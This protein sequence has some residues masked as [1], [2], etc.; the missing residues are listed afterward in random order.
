MLL[1]SLLA[2]ILFQVTQI[3]LISVILLLYLLK[4]LQQ[5]APILSI[6][7]L[8]RDSGIIM[9]KNLKQRPEN[10]QN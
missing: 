3:H 10:V 4:P 2:L 1:K 7:K 9:A 5:F 6:P 8:I